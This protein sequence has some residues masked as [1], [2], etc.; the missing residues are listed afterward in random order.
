MRHF[1]PAI[2]LDGASIAIVG[3]GP[4]AEAKARLFASSPAKVI[5]FTLDRSTSIPADLM[6]TTDI[7][8]GPVHEAKLAE[9]RFVFIATNDANLAA[10]LGVRARAG[11]ALV[12]V[13]DRPDLSDFNTPAI[14]DRGAV[15]VAIST[16]GAS[17]VLAVDI[18]AAIERVLRPGVGRLADIAASLRDV[19]K[20]ALPSVNARRI[21]WQRALRGAAADQ[22]DR[23]DE[24]GARRSILDDLHTRAPTKGIVHLVG[25]GPGDPDLLTLRAARLLREADVIVHDRLVPRAVLDMARRDATF[26]DVGKTKGQHPTPQHA[27]ED[28]LIEQARKG[29]RVVRLKG[30]DPFIFG[31]GGEELQALRAAD[32]DVDVT[33]GITAAL[34]CA[35]SSGAPLTH[36]DLAQAVTLVS[37]HTKA[38]GEHADDH[39]LAAANHTAVFYMGVDTAGDIE[40]RLLN[41]G[42]A[43]TTPVAVI[44]NGTRPDERV[45]TGTLGELAALVRTHNVVSPAIIIVGETAAL[46]V[47]RNAHGASQEAVA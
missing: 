33:P 15:T 13:V 20:A 16:G 32:I 24:A 7:R 22:A 43:S 45:L 8:P 29:H 2:R 26:I 19:V 42:R 3:S 28:I 5:W 35:A 38:N 14:V 12:N 21:F 39:A 47:E 23:S 30:G 44:E 6:D 10:R 27:I 9:A 37:G 1:L 25:A 4:M 41:A 40:R 11:G 46:A 17:P 18:R 34:A 31:R 36:R